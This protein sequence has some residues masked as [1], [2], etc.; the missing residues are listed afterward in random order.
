MFLWAHIC[1]LIYIWQLNNAAGQACADDTSSLL[2][3]GLEYVALDVVGGQ[4]IPKI[5]V[6]SSKCEARGWHHPVL[7]RLLCPVKWLTEFDADP[8]AFVACS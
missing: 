8:K 2:Q 6:V 1:V 5:S 7:A 4:L 3:S